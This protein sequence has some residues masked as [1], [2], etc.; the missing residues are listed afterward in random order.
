MACLTSVIEPLR[1]ANEISQTDTFEWRLISEEGSRVLSSAN[2]V[3]E[4]D[5]S[6]DD[7]PPLHQ[8]YV[9]S[10]PAA[11]F[12]NPVHSEGTLRRLE[13]HGL[14]LGAISGGVFPLARAGLLAGRQVSVHWC[15][16]TAFA[17]EFPDI[18]ATEDV[19]ARDRRC[20]TASG[21]AAAFELALHQIET[22]LSKDIATEV[23]CWFQHPMVRGEGVRQRKPTY[24]SESTDD[25]LP[26]IVKQAVGIF[27]GHIAEPIKV[28]DVAEE[29][30]VSV[31]RIERLFKRA[32]GQSPLHYY[33]GLRMK[34][35]RQLVLYSKEPLTEI[36]AAVGY[37]S[38][39]TLVQNY[40]LVFGIHPFADREKINMFRV[41]ENAPLPSV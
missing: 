39:G 24:Q 11:R 28:A 36:A 1:A 26:P 19:I 16:A 20:I 9:L 12:A 37:G 3:F 41:R 13:R 38:S 32:T 17:T 35:A 18:N 33:R 4:P 23:A 14:T 6:L 25:M 22:V 40:E 27:S 15:Y 8:L 5:H 10:G 7:L 21:A 30:G 2:V 34:A 29:I 31:R